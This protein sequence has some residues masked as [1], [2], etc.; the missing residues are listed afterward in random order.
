MTSP[1]PKRRKMVRAVGTHISRIS[2]V[3]R[4]TFRILLIALII[5]LFYLMV[6]WPDWKA[7][8]SGPIPKSN[9]IRDYEERRTEDKKLPAL[10]W[11]P[12]SLS[13]VPKHLQRAAIIA[14]DSRFYEHSGFDLIAFREAMDRNM[15]EGRFKF[16]ASTI[17]QQT[18][19][20]L[21]LSSSRTPLRKWHELV[22]TWGMEQNLS[23]H[24]ILEIYLN[25]AEFGTGIYGVQ[26][27]AQTY[28]GTSASGLTVAQSAEL[29]ASL[30]GPRKHNPATRTRFFQR[31]SHKI[32]NLLTRYPG[33]AA[34]A[35]A[36][37]QAP[38]F[39]EDPDEEVP[40]PPA[41]VTTD[42]VPPDAI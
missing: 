24:R 10:R 4:W 22:L 8:A 31:R 11:R 13:Q 42:Q 40:E 35:I 38:A 37:E 29:I 26:A 6:T 36:R 39:D 5:D 17:S 2:A 19:K 16:G 14:E 23:K 33:E 30:P 20:N 9:F 18:V 28:Y 25:I 27:A 41:V 7:L 15:D 1:N 12:V 3:L 32:L 34:E 21:F